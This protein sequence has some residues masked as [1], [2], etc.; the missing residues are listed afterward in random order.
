MTHAELEQEKQF[1]QLNFKQSSI[2]RSN[3]LAA[4]PHLPLQTRA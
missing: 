4:M 3:P 2:V 1:R